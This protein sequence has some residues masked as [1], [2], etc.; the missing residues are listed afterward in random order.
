MLLSLEEVKKKGGYLCFDCADKLRWR[1]DPYHLATMHYGRR[2][3]CCEEKA[4]A[5]WEDFL[6]A[7]RHVI[8]D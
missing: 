4:L 8:W 7:G 6:I 3:V 1:M 2:V 5:Y